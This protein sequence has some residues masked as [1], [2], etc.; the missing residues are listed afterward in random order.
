MFFNEISGMN[1]IT[2]CTFGLL[3]G[4]WLFE[5]DKLRIPGCPGLYPSVWQKVLAEEGFTDIIFLTDKADTK[6][7]QVVAA[8]SDG[9]VRQKYGKVADNNQAALIQLQ[10]P[11]L[12]ETDYTESA[13]AIT[14]IHDDISMPFFKEKCIDYLKQIISL[15]LKIPIQKI[16]SDEQ[17]GKYGIDS[18]LIVQLTNALNKDFKNIRS[19][20][21][22][23]YKTID[24]LAD[25]LLKTQKEIII[26]MFLKDRINQELR[27]TV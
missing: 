16:Y 25:Y 14:D 3:E 27:Q 6:W 13:V 19:T 4:W 12:K 23:E 10:S 1:I 21:L 15:T 9:C 20:I 11:I 24:A 26:K 7:Q 8:V 5:D 22:F 17:L 18:I 2:H